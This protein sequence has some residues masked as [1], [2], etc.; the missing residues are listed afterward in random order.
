MSHGPKQRWFMFVL[1]TQVYNSVL[2]FSYFYPT[3]VGHAHAIKLGNT[4]KLFYLAEIFGRSPSFTKVW[5]L[6]LEYQ[7]YNPISF[8]LLPI[9]SRQK[10]HSKFLKI[11]LQLF[12]TRNQSQRRCFYLKNVDVARAKQ[13]HSMY[14]TF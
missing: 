7:N 1:C 8:S 9:L 11:I 3:K 2:L 4:T 13:L 6:G 12:K 5:R 10:L 14:Q